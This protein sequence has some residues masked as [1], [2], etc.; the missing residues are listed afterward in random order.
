MMRVFLDATCWM[1]SAG[2]PNG[3]SAYIL[4]IAQADLFTIAVTEMILIEAERNIRDKM[5]E[6][7]FLSYMNTLGTVRI[8]V[9]EPATPDEER[10]WM[11]IVAEKDC[12]VLAGAYK[13]QANV[14]V[15]LD[16]K[17][18]LTDLVRQQFPILVQDTK[19]FLSAFRRE[20]G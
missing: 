7:A 6:T 11:G 17:H 3:G 5:P 8:E 19:E 16:R 14:L 15:T 1:A 10:R 20:A 9:V 18:I 13:A 2:N 4:Q 12:H